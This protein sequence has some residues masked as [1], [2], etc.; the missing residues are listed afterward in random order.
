[1]YEDNIENEDLDL[2]LDLDLDVEDED[3]DL[4][5]DDL[6]FDLDLD[7]EDLEGEELELDEET[8]AAATI[9]AK[10]S[11]A[12]AMATVVN[13]MSKMSPED[14]NKFAASIAKPG[15]PIP[16]GAAEKNKASIEAKKITEEE[17]KELFG[18]DLNE[19]F[20]QKATTLFEAAVNSRVTTEVAEVTEQLR[21]SFDETAKALEE[22]YTA[23]LEEEYSNLAD[24]LYEQIDSFM[25][26][27]VENWMEDNKLVVE[28]SLRAELAESFISQ[29]KDLFLEHNLEID[30]DSEDVVSE[31]LSVNEELQEKLDAV[32]SENIQLK[33]QKL[34]EAATA[35]L[36]EAMT[37]L[38]ASSAD[39]LKRLAENIEFTDLGEYKQKLN[40]LRESVSTGK[41]PSTGILI[42]ESEAVSP[43]QLDE[44]NKPTV[45]NSRMATYLDVASRIAP[46]T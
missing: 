32:L 9:K 24:T 31:L 41:K 3:Y 15:N 33:D 40:I 20:S 10:P 1:M 38:A 6:D 16:D 19:E 22:A 8:A 28:K 35:S 17:L 23:A 45:T 26:Y 37:G 46:K 30:E 13:A 12:S 27:V 39:K 44:E 43:D 18:E 11:R 4:E 25:N 21:E 34:V 36:Q 5:D 2:D 14:L 42:E 7:D 29:V